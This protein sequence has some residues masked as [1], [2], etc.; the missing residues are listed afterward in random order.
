MVE[1]T[2]ED[3]SPQEQ[4]EETRK[5]TGTIGKVPGEGDEGAAPSGQGSGGASETAGDGPSGGGDAATSGDVGGDTGDAG[6]SSATG[7]GPSGWGVE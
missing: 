4:A 7:D 1:E 6:D 2:S 5:R 3:Q